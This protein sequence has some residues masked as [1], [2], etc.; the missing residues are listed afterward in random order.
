[1]P[2]TALI[3]DKQERFALTQHSGERLRSRPTSP[4]LYSR[5]V[6]TRLPDAPDA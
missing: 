3:V 4:T 1:V 5:R 2:A 6:V